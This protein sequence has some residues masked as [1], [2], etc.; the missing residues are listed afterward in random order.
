MKD[1]SRKR[2][3][4]QNKLR[5]CRKFI[6][7]LEPFKDPQTNIQPNIVTRDS[8]LAQ[9]IEKNRELAIRVGVRIGALQDED[10][11]VVERGDVQTLLHGKIQNAKDLSNVWDAT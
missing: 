9:E 10:H 5:A 2:A 4:L 6:T 1:L 7:L 11:R 8:K 3:A